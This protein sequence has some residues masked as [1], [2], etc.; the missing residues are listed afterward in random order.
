M[1]NCSRLHEEKASFIATFAVW[2]SASVVVWSLFFYVRVSGGICC[3]INTC[4]TV[5]YSSQYVIDNSLLLITDVKSLLSE[6]LS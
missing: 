3:L 1:K 4:N 5:N 2:T 6:L